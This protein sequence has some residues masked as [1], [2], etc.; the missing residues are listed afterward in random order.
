MS[1]KLYYYENCWCFLSVNFKNN[2]IYW[3]D[4]ECIYDKNGNE[5]T[6]KKEITLDYIDNKNILFFIQD[7]YYYYNTKTKIINGLKDKILQLS[8]HNTKNLMDLNDFLHNEIDKDHIRDE[9]IVNI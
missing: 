6:D 7:N 1:I 2:N 3:I 5:I 8:I 9:Y 4:W